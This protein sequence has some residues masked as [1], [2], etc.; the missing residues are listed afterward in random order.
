M[1]DK[2]I[3]DII[4]VGGG[5]AGIFTSIYGSQSG[6]KVLLL[7]KM[8][9]LGKKLLIAG[10]GQCN[11]THTGTKD[12][13]IDKYGDNGSFLKKAFYKFPPQA[14][15]NFFAE[16][17]LPLVSTEKGK[18]FPNTFKSLDVLS[19]LKKELEKLDVQIETK[20]EVLEVNFND[21]FQ[22]KTKDNEFYSRNL[23]IATGGLSYNVTGSSGDGYKFANKMGLKLK[24][25]KPSLTPCYVK[26]YPYSNLQGVSFKNIL[27]ELWRDNKK[28]KSA[29]GDLLF[30]HKNISG[31][32]IIDNSRYFEKGD[33]LIINYSG[34]PYEMFSENIR[35]IINN[36]GNKMIKNIFD[37]PNFSERFI[38][39]ALK[40]CSIDE[41]KKCNLL[42][43][44]EIKNLINYLAKFEFEISKLEGY[45]RAMATSGGID[46]SELNK[47]TMETKKIK[48]LYF[49][50][51]V[52]DIDGDTG[53]YNIQAAFSMGALAGISIRR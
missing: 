20:M 25:T 28:I 21:I 9:K 47:N 38:K 31:P 30:T 4:V 39:F 32:V 17:N 5:P 44:N 11:L 13:F 46:L 43:K 42:N 2:N 18:Y 8:E 51:E 36:N 53:G 6:N 29:T 26:D 35:K 22:V 50:G 19:V 33:K 12:E 41:N 16:R 52:T 14:L 34:I 24:N 1:K 45:E 15:I 23:V 7:E 48:G 40:Y 3:Y 10:Q 27:L 49:V 37:N